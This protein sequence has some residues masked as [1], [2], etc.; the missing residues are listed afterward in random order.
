MASPL[1]SASFKLLNRMEQSR[2][3]DITNEPTHNPA[4]EGE[5]EKMAWEGCSAVEHANY[6][7]QKIEFERRKARLAAGNKVAASANQ[8]DASNKAGSSDTAAMP[9]QQ[10]S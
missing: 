1:P 4:A 3:P 2:T 6:K 7:M 9:K 8:T 5:C 10:Q